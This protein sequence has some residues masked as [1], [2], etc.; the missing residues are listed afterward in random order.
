MDFNTHTVY[1][2]GRISPHGS[3]YLLETFGVG[4]NFTFFLYSD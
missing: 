2:S 3:I 1:V 4:P